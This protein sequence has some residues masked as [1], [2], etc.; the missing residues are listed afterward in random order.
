MLT[1]LLPAFFQVL[2][3]VCPPLRLVASASA[4]H[5]CPGC[6]LRGE[7]N[8]NLNLFPGIAI[9]SLHYTTTVRGQQSGNTNQF[10]KTKEH[11]LES[12]SRAINNVLSE[13]S[14]AVKSPAGDFTAVGRW[15]QGLHFPDFSREQ[16][17]PGQL[18]I[19]EFGVVQE[20]SLQILALFSHLDLNMTIPTAHTDSPSS[21]CST[22]NLPQ[23]E[24]QCAQATST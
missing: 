6:S 2:V 16:R 1:D 13:H 12:N 21:C 10:L 4:H 23:A 17:G 3:Y 22:I 8:E 24:Q 19:V 18:A 15:R 7:K 9:Y 5:W 14:L 20:A 11:S